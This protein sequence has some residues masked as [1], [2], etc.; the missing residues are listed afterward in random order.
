MKIIVTAGG[1]GGHIYPALSMINK[2]KKEEENLE[3]LYIGTHNRMEKDIVPPLG[4]KYEALEIYGFTKDIKRD[5]KNVSLIIKAYKKC[6]KIM[7]E[8]KPDVVLGFGGYVTFPVIKA[9]HKLG[10]KTFIHEQNSIPG[11]SNKALSKY[12]DIIGVT[13]EKTKE[14]FKD[15]NKVV[16]TGHPRGDEAILANPVDKKTLGLTPNKKLVVVVLGS[17]GSTSLNDKIV[18]YAKNIKNKDYELLYITGK[19]VYDRI[20]QKELPSNVKIIPFYDNLIGLFKNTDVVI[21]RAGS[22]VLNELI[23]L[24][25]PSIIIPSPNVANN[26]Q[27]YNAKDLAEENACIMLEEKNVTKE[28]LQDSVEKILNDDSSKQNMLK[29]LEKFQ[30]TNSMSIIYNSIKEILK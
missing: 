17:L 21:S 30:V 5:I 10:I 24:K 18:D 1:T 13:F 3:V 6:I 7:K 9:A 14:Y 8:Y 23:A 4:I 20:N 19:R 11:K 26:H 2:F 22:G 25:V 29:N 27:Y 16:F 28:I 15:K 12:A